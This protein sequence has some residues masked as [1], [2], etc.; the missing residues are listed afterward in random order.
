[1]EW[2]RGR[3]QEQFDAVDVRKYHECGFSCRKD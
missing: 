3:D 1:M 2:S